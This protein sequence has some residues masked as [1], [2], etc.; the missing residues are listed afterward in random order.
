MAIIN[1]YVFI[2]IFYEISVKAGDLQQ[3]SSLKPSS[4]DPHLHL[5]KK[6]KKKSARF[7]RHLPSSDDDSRQCF[8]D[9]GSTHWVR[10][11]PPLDNSSCLKYS[12]IIGEALIEHCISESG[13]GAT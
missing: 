13:A 5:K 2:E 8:N 9:K 4:A 6:K 12:E 11:H 10:Y 3:T 1:F 7:A